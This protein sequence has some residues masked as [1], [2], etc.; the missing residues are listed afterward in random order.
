MFFLLPY[1]CDILLLLCC[2]F[3]QLTHILDERM[4]ELVED[5]EREKALKDVA[6]DTTKEKGNVV[7]VVEKRA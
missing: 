7:D 1:T 3:A 6:E 5:M 4:K 2:Q